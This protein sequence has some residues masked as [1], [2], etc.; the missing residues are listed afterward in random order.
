[1]TDVDLDA[2]VAEGLA[3][4]A[5]APDLDALDAAVAGLFG[6]R[7]AVSAVQR[8][9]G[10]LDEAT[11]RERGRA[12]N[13]ARA[14]LQAAIAERRA[15]LEDRR[16][17]VVLAAEAVDV[18]LPP[19]TPRR[20]SLHPITETVEALVDVFAGLGYTALSGP[21]A[22]SE[23]FNF[24]ALNLPRDHPARSEDD[25]IYL[26]PL[27]PGGPAW[28]T[29]LR[30]STSPMQVRT[31]LATPPPLHVVV[32]GRVFRQDT[33]DA[34]H[35]PVFHQI[36]GLSVDTDISMADLR[37][38][39]AAVARAVLGPRTRIRLLPDHFPFT[40]PSCQVEAWDGSRWLELLGAGMVHPTVLEAGG[41]DPEAVG[42]FA[43]G[44]GIER[45][46]MLRYGIDDLRLFSDNDLRFLAAF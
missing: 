5:A 44:I 32:P 7:G 46:A 6:R 31:M 29:L 16:D 40:E 10:Q 1:M 9:L 17:R 13:D 21:E 33:P 27:T 28:S 39:L 20:G 18:T 35:A 26:E 2:V 43:F 42:G 22:E 30:T 24:T 45:V 14:R 19:R 3:A 36:E 41:Y 11:R 37:G 12:V 25:T 38:T 8:S 4:V 34:T 23:W 15:L